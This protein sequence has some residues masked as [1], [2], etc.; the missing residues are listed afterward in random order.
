MAKNQTVDQLK[1]ILKT[2]G[3]KSSFGKMRKDELITTLINLKEKDFKSKAA[4]ERADSISNAS[5]V[6]RPNQSRPSKNLVAE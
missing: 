3:Y 6:S 4:K 1:Q 2:I 5:Q